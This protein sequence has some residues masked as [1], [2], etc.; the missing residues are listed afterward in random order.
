MAKK[1]WGTEYW[2]TILR[3]RMVE[4]METHADFYK[5]YLGQYEIDGQVAKY[6]VEQSEWDRVSFAFLAFS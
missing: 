4:E 6:D 3:Q 5:E 2:H 1:V